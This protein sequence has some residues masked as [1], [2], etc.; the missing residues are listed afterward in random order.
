LL[1]FPLAVVLLLLA[2]DVIITLFTTRYAASIPIFMA[3][4]LT[5]LPSVFCVDAVLRAYAQTRFLFIMNLVRLVLVI[6]LISWFLSTFGLI[7]AV[8]V[9]LLAT[10][11]VRVFSIVRI[12]NLLKARFRDILPW[13]QLAG[14]AVCAVVAMPP[15]YWVSRNTTMPRLLML[16]CAGAAYWATYAVIAYF[17]FLRERHIEPA[18][19][20][21]AATPNLLTR[22]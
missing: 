18:P 22:T 19:A 11:L 8:L 3:W 5:I 16:A 6:A 10:S 12:G 14:V 2:R 9:T 21:V 13:G 17:A 7:G 20:R 1:I 4:T 15:A